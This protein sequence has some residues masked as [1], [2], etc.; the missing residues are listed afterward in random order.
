MILYRSDYRS[1]ASIFREGFRA[2]GRN[3]NLLWHVRGTTLLTSL[4]REKYG[5]AFISTSAERNIAV[6]F[7]RASVV[8]R[9]FY[10]YEINPTDN[11]YKVSTCFE[12]ACIEFI[13]MEYLATLEQFQIQQEYVAHNTIPTKQI[14]RATRYIYKNERR[15]YLRAETRKNA[16]YESSGNYHTNSNAY[17]PLY[18]WNTQLPTALGMEV[19]ELLLGD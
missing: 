5:S 17:H 9:D 4:N 18:S 13:E 6:D 16:H 1:P 14:F 11:F 3:D 15:K 19:A 10:L 7:A 2:W 8:P 12:T